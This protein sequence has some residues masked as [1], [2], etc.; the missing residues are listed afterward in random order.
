MQWNT[1]D[2]PPPQYAVQFR[3]SIALRFQSSGLLFHGS[4]TTAS[5]L[6]RFVRRE[7]LGILRVTV[8]RWKG[9]ATPTLSRHNKLTRSRLDSSIALSVLCSITHRACGSQW[10]SLNWNST[11]YAKQAT[12]LLEACWPGMGKKLS[13]VGR[14]PRELAARL[15][16]RQRW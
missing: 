7:K 8:V 2:R 9:W 16:P 10:Q 5:F 4:K 15:P 14:L 13:Q 12:S 1:R 11:P 6:E 3:T